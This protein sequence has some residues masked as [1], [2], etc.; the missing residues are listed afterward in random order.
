MNKLF[1][2]AV[3]LIV[4]FRPGNLNAQD[5]AAL[6]HEARKLELSFKDVD[7]LQLYLQVLSIQ[8]SHIVALCKTSELYNLIGRRLPDKEKQRS[9]YQASQTYA[10]KALKVNPNNS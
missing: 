3:T 7:A 5:P 10:E 8:P 9:Y 6:I 2:I 4:A 1:L